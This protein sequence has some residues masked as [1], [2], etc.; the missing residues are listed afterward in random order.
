MADEPRSPLV[1]V[2][3]RFRLSSAERALFTRS[4]TD[5]TLEKV[6]LPTAAAI[7]FNASAV[8]DFG[9]RLPP[10]RGW[11]L[12][13]QAVGAAFQTYGD[14]DPHPG[15]FEKAAM[16]LRGITQGH[17]FNDGNKRTG[18]LVA[19][20]FLDLVGHPYPPRLSV[21]GVTTLAFGVSAG[22]IRD[23]AVIAAELERLW[24]GE[25]RTEG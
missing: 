11:G 9:G 8:N 25:D 19:G 16:L 5:A 7:L 22:T 18:F 15:N 4:D 2:V 12:V 3:R 13:E 17:P 20:F 10:T 24:A 1:D 23:V 14:E 6:R 21:A